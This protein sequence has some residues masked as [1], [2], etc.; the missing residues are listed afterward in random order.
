MH[1]SAAHEASGQHAETLDEDLRDYL[2]VYLERF[3]SS[4]DIVMLLEADHGMRYGDWYHHIEAFQENRLPVMFL[5]GSRSVLDDIPGV[6]DTLRHN[7]YR[8]NSKLDMRKT[9]LYLAELPYTQPSQSHSPEAFNLFTE[10]IR[11]NRTC[12]EAKIPPWHCSCL[13]LRELNLAEVAQTELGELLTSLASHAVAVFNEEAYSVKHSSKGTL[14]VKLHLNRVEA[15]Y[16]V[17][18]TSMTEELKLEI[19]VLESASFRMEVT[20]LVTSNYKQV[21]EA[22][23]LLLPVLYN[24]YRKSVRLLT[25]MRLDRYVGPCEAAARA[26]ELNPEYCICPLV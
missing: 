17:R 22:N 18:L 6:Y 24:G 26:L 25:S 5:I 12:E 4:H 16:G 21:T 3:S 23:Q 13:E 15:A 8:L 11:D 9:M 1:L 19:S 14:C 7:S 10:K 2:R 20:F